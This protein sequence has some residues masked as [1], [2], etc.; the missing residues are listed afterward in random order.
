MMDPDRS[1][2]GHVIGVTKR[3]MNDCRVV[4][5]LLQ[6]ETCARVNTICSP[7]RNNSEVP[8]LKSVFS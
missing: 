8:P 6:N 2:K 5:H 1:R 3:G 4:G 7:S